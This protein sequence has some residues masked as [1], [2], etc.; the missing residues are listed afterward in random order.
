MQGGYKR[1]MIREARPP[2]RRSIK[3]KTRAAMAA[4]RPYVYGEDNTCL[5]AHYLQ[6][7]VVKAR[8]EERMLKTL[9]CRWSLTRVENQNPFQKINCCPVVSEGKICDV[10][11]VLFELLS[12]SK[13]KYV[14]RPVD[15]VTD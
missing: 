7:R 1:I 13:Q 3:F 11:I 5:S 10:A 2:V 15:S 4:N 14:S 6:G 12:P 8:A 9:C